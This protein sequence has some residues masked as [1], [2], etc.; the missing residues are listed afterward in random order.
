M[1]S[2]PANDATPAA[3][4][5]RY[6]ALAML[7]V[8]YT[9]NFL[10]RQIISI[11]KDPIAA[12]LN[13]TDTQLGLMGGVAF[14]L[15][16][17]TLARPNSC[18]SKPGCTPGAASSPSWACRRS[19]SP[20]PSPRPSNR[21]SSRPPSLPAQSCSATSSSGANAPDARMTLP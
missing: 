15:L 2:T 21:S 3:P 6:M 13:L 1:T 9:L 8:V 20:W 11:L 18:M 16:Y 4:R 14:A 12:E 10:D 19:S 5:G 7:I 17:T